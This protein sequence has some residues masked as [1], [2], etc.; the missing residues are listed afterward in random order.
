VL[1]VLPSKIPT[2]AQYLKHTFP[3]QKQA[4]SER[5]GFSLMESV[6]YD[7]MP[8]SASLSRVRREGAMEIPDPKSIFEFWKTE[9]S[10]SAGQSAEDFEKLAD[11]ILTKTG[12]R[13]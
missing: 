9:N 12:W 5:H 1:G 2:N 13:E 7:R 11:E 6:I 3:R 10:S 8:L 4:I